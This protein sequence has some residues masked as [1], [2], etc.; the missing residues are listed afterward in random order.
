MSTSVLIPVAVVMWLALAARYYLKMP[1]NRRVVSALVALAT[2][3]VGVGAALLRG[4]PVGWAFGCA[5]VAT[6]IPWL[7]TNFKPELMVDAAREF[8]EDVAEEQE[9]ASQK[10]Q[11][12]AV[13]LVFLV[14]LV[15][16][17]V[18]WDDIPV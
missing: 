1:A 16:A 13:L 15:W 11:L 9:D 18:F 5:A 4:L 10:Y 12:R 3:A 8:G 14:V 6:A 7:A 2:P 17:V